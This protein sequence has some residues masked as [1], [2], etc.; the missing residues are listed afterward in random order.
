[1]V[2][3]VASN[4]SSS[5]E[6]S[7]TY[8]LV[9]AAMSIEGTTSESGSAGSSTSSTTRS[10]FVNGTWVTT[11]GDGSSATWD[12]GK[13]SSIGSGGYSY[14]V[15]GSGVAGSIAENGDWKWGSR[16]DTSSGFVDGAWVTSGFGGSESKV[17]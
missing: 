9:N 12:G 5:Y 3:R 2:V 17:S 6:T 16:F 8:S 13:G 10:E 4:D 1:L 11:S 7:G 14:E 15:D